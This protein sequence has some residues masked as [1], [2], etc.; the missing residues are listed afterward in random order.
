VEELLEFVQKYKE[1]IPLISAGIIA[2]VGALWTAV[3]YAF[4]RRRDHNK[5][6][7]ETYHRLIDELVGGKGNGQPYVDRQCAI[8]FE[9]RFYRRYYPATRRILAGLKQDW[10]TSPLAKTRLFHE[11]DLTI[12][13]T[14]GWF[15]TRH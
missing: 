12:A 8:V 2:I 9:L 10:A 3:Q 14:K 5:E 15:W 7:F 11:M 6:V 4:A 1:S 13:K